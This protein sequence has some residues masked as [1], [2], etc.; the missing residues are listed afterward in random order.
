MRAPVLPDS[1]ANAVHV[2]P[3]PPLYKAQISCDLQVNGLCG[4]DLIEGFRGENPC[5]HP[6]K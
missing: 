3:L 5:P 2:P 4:R 1:G 6:H